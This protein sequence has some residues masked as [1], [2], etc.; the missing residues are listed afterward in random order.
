M[1]EP[2][3]AI[4]CVL[5]PPGDT[6]I[7]S[8][9]TAGLSARGW[10][11]TL[12]APEQLPI[13]AMPAGAE[14]IP[15]PPAGGYVKRLRQSTRVVPYLRKLRPNLV[16][17]P[18][19]ELMPVL[20]RYRKR[21]RTPVV[22]DRHENFDLGREQA[23]GN[24][25]NQLLTSAYIRYERYATGILDGVIVVLKEMVPK[26][27]PQANTIVAHNFPTRD[28]LD[29][30][31][32]EPPPDTLQYTCVH[33]G[34][35]EHIR[36]AME[37]LHIACELLATRRRS[38]FTLLLGGRFAPGLHYEMTS[39]IAQHGLAGSVSLLPEK[40]P[41]DQVVS[42][43]RASQIGLCPYLNNKMAA[44]G[45]QNKLV[46][47]MG[48]GLPVITSPSTMNG[49]IVRDSGCGALHWAN[50]T[51]AIAD[52]I[53]QWLDD[54]LEAQRRG[55]AGLV[56]A[57]EHLVWEKELDRLEPWLKEIIAKRRQENGG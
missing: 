53:E 27:N 12:L 28:V 26:L 38:D 32:A 13:P 19:P 50:E 3:I 7:F 49:Q 55:K 39:Y 45:L 5:H 44:I 2:H 36:G 10:R 20:L 37:L 35:I 34:T 6:R 47:Y 15:M 8:R 9:L 23:K 25:V 42:L 43:L 46:E 51:Q 31:Q 54:P 30:L 18:D 56:Y 21:Y 33:V 17:F 41:H 52:T 48:A 16:L 22:F 40:L 1:L 14:Y 57:C 24:V 4:A 29:K 11:V